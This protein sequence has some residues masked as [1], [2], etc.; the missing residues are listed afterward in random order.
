MQSD[1]WNYA[2]HFQARNF[3]IKRQKEGRLVLMYRNTFTILTEMISITFYFSEMKRYNQ[4][5]SGKLS[6][7]KAYLKGEKIIFKNK[8][9]V[10]FTIT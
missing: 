8:N 9:F 3:P 6:P 2:Y 4:I 1:Y 5:C 10:I 7:S